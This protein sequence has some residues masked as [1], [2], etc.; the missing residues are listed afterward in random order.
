[1][2]QIMF[3]LRLPRDLVKI[4]EDNPSVSILDW[5]NF[6][7]DFYEVRGRRRD[8]LEAATRTLLSQNRRKGF[9]LQKK[10]K[11]GPEAVVLIM[12][13]RHVLSGSIEE[14][15]NDFGC[16]ALYPFVVEGGW[17][18]IRGI[19]LEEGKVADM[20]SR[21]GAMGDL[22][23]ESKTKVDRDILRENFL[24]PTG[25]LVTD[26]TSKQAESLLAA[27]DFG[28]YRVPRKA[29]FEDIARA[30]G[31]PR[32]TYEEHVRKGESKVINA[33]APYL[34]LFFGRGNR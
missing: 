15:M 6:H 5:C 22:E 21:L 3:R 34:S 30:V 28:Y 25:A 13:C 2:I 10:M 32:T 26:L 23:I 12:K 24:I 19:S 9:A 18:R 7:I 1:M 17:M 29:R 33:A 4:T 27:V 20:L 8:D 31:I 14:T 16:V 11:V